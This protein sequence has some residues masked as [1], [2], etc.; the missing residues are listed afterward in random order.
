MSTTTF[1]GANATWMPSFR[2]FEPTF[3][4]I[5][6]ELQDQNPAIT[7]TIMFAINGDPVLEFVSLEPKE[8][9]QILNATKRAYN[10]AIREW[11]TTI[12]DP[13]QY[14]GSMYC[15]S[16]LKALMLF[17]ERTA[18]IPAGRVTINDF[19]VW[20]APVWI[21]DI[22]LEVMAAYPTVR[23]QQPALAETLLAARRSEGTGNLDLSPV[24]DIEFR[25]IVEAAGW[26]YQRYVAGGGKA[27][28]A[29][30]FFVEVSIKIDELFHLL[31]SD[32]RAQNP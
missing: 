10:R 22:A 27:S 32:K 2:A 23:L 29:P 24:S 17:D 3:R 16:E 19:V 14:R 13:A 7:K 9:G 4:L 1:V 15:F 12:P 26:V 21:G 31:R 11:S 8:F 28:A 30:D 20:D 18:P 5:A 25:A 6:E